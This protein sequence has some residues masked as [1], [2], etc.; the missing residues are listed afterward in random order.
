MSSNKIDRHNHTQNHSG[1]IARHMEKTELRQ[2]DS[3]GALTTI[4]SKYVLAPTLFDKALNFNA[5]Q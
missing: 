2:S 5:L 4:P 1:Y 3:S